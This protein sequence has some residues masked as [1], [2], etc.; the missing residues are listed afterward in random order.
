[1]TLATEEVI[2]FKVISAVI[3]ATNNLMSAPKNLIS[4]TTKVTLTTKDA[5]TVCSLGYLCCGFFNSLVNRYSAKRVFFANLNAEA[6]TC[7]IFVNFR[8]FLWKSCHL[9]IVYR[10]VFSI[11]LLVVCKTPRNQNTNRVE[12]YMPNRLLWMNKLSNLSMIYTRPRYDTQN[13][14]KGLQLLCSESMTA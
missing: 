4:V 8:V 6:T 11:I 12:V 3:L 1:M 5:I 2:T 10:Q 14:D 7:K 13:A 9:R